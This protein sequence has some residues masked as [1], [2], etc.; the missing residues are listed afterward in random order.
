MS[1]TGVRRRKPVQKIIK[2]AVESNLLF[3]FL[4]FTTTHSPNPEPKA[5]TVITVIEFITPDNDNIIL[6]IPPIFSRLNYEVPECS[7]PYHRN[8]NLSL[9]VNLT[10]QGYDLGYRKREL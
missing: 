10:K 1:I 7:V 5:K 8:H 6:L 3:D 2:P 9:I 4:D